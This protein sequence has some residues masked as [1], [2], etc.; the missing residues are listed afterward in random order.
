MATDGNLLQGEITDFSR[1]KFHDRDQVEL[2]LSGFL[3]ALVEEQLHD[4]RIEAGGL[5][6][7]EASP[8]EK[9]LIEPLPQKTMVDEG[10]QD[11]LKNQTTSS[12]RKRSFVCI[13][14]GKEG[15]A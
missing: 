9:P 5:R 15:N 11:P 2:F 10:E 13:P 12:H 6:K 7:Q 4:S 3:R 1:S 8:Q 14:G